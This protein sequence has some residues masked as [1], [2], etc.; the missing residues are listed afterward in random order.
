MFARTVALA[1]A[2][3]AQFAWSV[4]KWVPFAVMINECV[5]SLHPVEGNSMQPTLNREHG[6]RDWI[7]ANR[8]A[9]PIRGDVIVL[10][11]VPCIAN[12]ACLIFYNVL[13]L[14]AIRPS[15]AISS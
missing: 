8:L 15:T 9:A 14:P 4:A 1:S 11:C 13:W 10:A 6:Q 12:E 3:S 2:P 7:L 5:V